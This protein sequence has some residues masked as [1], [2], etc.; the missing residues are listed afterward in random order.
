[1][2]AIPPSGIIR[3]F[4][5][6]DMRRKALDLLEMDVTSAHDPMLP[7]L[8]EVVVIKAVHDAVSARCCRT[9]R[10][11]KVNRLLAAVVVATRQPDMA[12]T[13]DE[14]KTHYLVR[15]MGVHGEQPIDHGPSY[16]AVIVSLLIIRNRVAPTDRRPAVPLEHA[17]PCRCPPR[18]KLLSTGSACTL[19]LT[20][21]RT[22]ISVSRFCVKH[23][24][25]AS[26]FAPLQMYGSEGSSRPARTR[27]VISY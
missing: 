6:T 18:A 13:A 1:M 3:A 16:S 23:L 20:R 17:Q 25:G 19:R 15:V 7:R 24:V 12:T 8:F 5:E 21:E 2:S 4:D 27:C 9:D 14:P 26:A 22:L 11:D 10:A